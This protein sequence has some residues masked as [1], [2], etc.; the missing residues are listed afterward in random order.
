MLR[1]TLFT[2]C[3]VMPVMI[4]MAPA[5]RADSYT[6]NVDYCGNSCLG[7]LTGGTVTLSSPASNEVT[8]SVALQNV[9]SYHDN[10][11]AFETFAFN[12]NGIS[13]IKVGTI[14]AGAGTWSVFNTAAGSLHEDGAGN[15]M[16]GID[17]SN[18]GQSVNDTTLSFT[19]T[20]TGLTTDSFHQ[21]SSGGSPSAYFEADVTNTVGG[22]TCTGIIGSDGT[23]TAKAGGSN[24]G[25]STGCAATPNTPEASSIMFFGTGL[26]AAGWVLRRRLPS[27]WA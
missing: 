23:G 2:I 15:F 24:P 18:C 7:G 20:A 6:L 16:Y 25:G 8:V 12:L 1:A 14:T 4:G 17:C 21:L 5:V 3:A 9:T 11:A 19:V 27:L 26:L 22:K 10:T 13:S